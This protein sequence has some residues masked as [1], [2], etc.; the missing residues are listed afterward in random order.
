VTFPD[1]GIYWY[2]PHVREDIQQDLGLYGNMLVRPV[3][4][5]REV[6]REEVLML[7]DLLLGD[8]GLTPR[9]LPGRCH[10]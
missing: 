8:D 2:H 9:P 5:R 10:R 4:A 6:N 3:T 1:A 7:D